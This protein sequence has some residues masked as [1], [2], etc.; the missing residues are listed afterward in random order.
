LLFL[1][2]DEAELGK[3][4]KDE[5]QYFS[6]MGL[7]WLAL[8]PHLTMISQWN[9]TSIVDARLWKCI[10]AY[11]NER[12]SFMFHKDQERTP[13]RKCK[14]D[15][16]AWIPTEE[17]IIPII[18]WLIVLYFLYRHYDKKVTYLWLPYL[19]PCRDEFRLSVYSFNACNILS[20]LYQI[21]HRKYYGWR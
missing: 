13:G 20:A 21:I 18:V 17:A 19:I 1:E 9:Q 5:S 3:S 16:F 7:K 4:T 8:S 2:D 14:H 10:T 12:E 15:C 11:L 6:C